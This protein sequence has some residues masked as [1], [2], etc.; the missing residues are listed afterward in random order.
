MNNLDESKLMLPSSSEKRMMT[1]IPAITVKVV[2]IGSLDEFKA[3]FGNMKN[4]KP[5]VL[6]NGLVIA[7]E[8]RL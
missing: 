2:K 4:L 3:R 1:V 5:A 8:Q 6:I 7:N